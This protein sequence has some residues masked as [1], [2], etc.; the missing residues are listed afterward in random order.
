MV[1]GSK[2]WQ[3]AVCS[4]SPYFKTPGVMHI[5][6]KTDVDDVQCPC[7]GLPTFRWSMAINYK[8]QVVKEWCFQQTLVVALSREECVWQDWTW[9]PTLNLDPK[10]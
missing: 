8:L 6:E 7:Y 10:P 5:L 3:S 4:Q 1:I 2:F 9:N